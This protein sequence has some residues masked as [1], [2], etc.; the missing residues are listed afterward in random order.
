MTAMTAPGSAIARRALGRILDVPASSLARA[1]VALDKDTGQRT[2]REAS[3]CCLRRYG[4]EARLDPGPGAGRPIPL[5]QLNPS[6]AA[7]VPQKGPLVIVSNHPGLYDALA[8]FA[9]I[10]REDI[11]TLAARRPLLEA[12]PNIS[13]RLLAI[14]PGTSAAVAVK[15]ALRHLRSGGALL[16]FPAGQIEPDARVTPR[17]QPLIRPWKPG[18]DTLLSAAVRVKPDLRVVPAFVSGVISRRA[19]SVVRILGRQ[20]G[21]TDALVP[22]LQITVPGFND[23]DVRLRFGAASAAT[24]DPVAR[25]RAEIESMAI[26]AQFS[27]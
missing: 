2:F 1:L 24:G 8:L 6:H 13:K 21:L 20:T 5:A 26:S 25:L 12:L 16:H 10:G 7:P 27:S 4:V 17:G 23:V 18:L 14:D 11:A 19:L 3:L 15:Q 9:A 22:L